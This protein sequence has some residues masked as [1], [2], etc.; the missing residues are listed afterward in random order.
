MS[1]R[2]TPRA[3]TGCEPAYGAW[4]EEE[5]GMA[6][7]R[8]WITGARAVV[9][10]ALAEAE[11]PWRVRR[12]VALAFLVLP[13]TGAVAMGV[14]ALYRPLF[15]WLTRE[16]GAL[17]WA[18][19]SADVVGLV[20]ATWVA[21]TL[22]RRADRS[23]AALWAGFAALLLFIAGEEI[24]WGQ[25]IFD[26]STPDVL[27]DRNH[28]EESNVHNIRVVQDTI[29]VGFMLVGLYGGAVAVAL[30]RRLPSARRPRWFDLVVPPTILASSF[31]VV[32]AYKLLR[33][34]VLQSPRFTI[35]KY[36]E[37]VELLTA[38]ALASFAVLT[39]RRIGVRRMRGHRAGS[40]L[41]GDG[42]VI[43]LRERVVVEDQDRVV[44]PGRQ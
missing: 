32:F 12:P 14:I 38:V 1:S 3:M 2:A 17:E 15:R 34:V 20:A 11:Q 18:Q 28:Q 29:N 6:T 10:D 27:L 22:W 19:F 31:L 39:S 26:L 24:S 44:G 43:D 40:A 9:D 4:S 16:D 7:G 30:R 21:V 41:G 13:P 25:R 35:V 37:Y 42:E 5:H 36:G 23:G 33:L 8:R